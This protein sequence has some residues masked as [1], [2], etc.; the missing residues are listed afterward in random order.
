[1]LKL[2]NTEQYLEMRR[3]ALAND[4]ITEIPAWEYDVN[5]TWDQNRYTNW[6]K[7]LVG[8]AAYNNTV[9]LSATGG[10]ESTRFILGGSF[11]KETTVF[12]GDFNYKKTTAFA[13][14]TH[15]SEDKRLRIQFSANYGQDKK[16]FW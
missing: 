4:G 6:Q 14:I 7:E 5:G 11:M 12:P 10:S 1:M 9:R 13:N 15:H 2:L 8:N 3:E 16:T